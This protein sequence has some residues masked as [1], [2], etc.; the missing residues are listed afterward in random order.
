MLA[1]EDAAL[2]QRLA[3]DRDRRAEEAMASNE[4]LR[5]PPSGEGA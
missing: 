5:E 4:K 1:L 3:A 2:A